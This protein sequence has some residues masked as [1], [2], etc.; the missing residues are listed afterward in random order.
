MNTI[1]SW[2]YP[3]SF[4]REPYMTQWHV[5]RSDD[6]VICFIQISQD[7]NVPQ[8][9]RLGYLLEKMLLDK[10]N[11]VAFMEECIIKYNQDIEK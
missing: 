9:T 4:H 3:A 7:E 5:V 11:D 8:W 6:P 1:E 2:S 10:A